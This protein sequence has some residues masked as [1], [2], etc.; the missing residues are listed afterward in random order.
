[1]EIW[2]LLKTES[3]WCRDAPAKAGDGSVVDPHHTSARSF[4]IVGAMIKCYLP[5]GGLWST[6]YEV[7]RTA[8][9]NAI[10]SS[11]A[12][13]KDMYRAIK[14]RSIKYIQLG[15]LNSKIGFAFVR[16]ILDRMKVEKKEA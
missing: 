16:A 7:K 4:S 9:F 2:E 8:V 10:A 14:R 12:L 3:D 5:P 15:D 1:M 11:A 13:R 6:E